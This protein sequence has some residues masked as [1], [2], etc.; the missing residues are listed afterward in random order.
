MKHIKLFEDFDLDKFLENPDKE[1]ADDNSPEINIG[2][3]V[4]S[5]RGKGRVVDMDDSF[6]TVE[7]H[8]SKENRV[9][10]PLFAL[11]KI[12]SDTIET[13]KV[14][15]SKAELADLVSQARQYNDYLNSMEDYDNEED[16]T[17][18]SAS[19]VNFDTLLSF[20][21]DTVVEV[22]TIKNKDTAYDTY[23]EYHELINLVGSIA[24]EIQ[25]ARPDLIDE[26]DAALENFPS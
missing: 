21:Q 7:L 5:Y 17:V 15:D 13:T 9:K 20:I 19:Q 12:S 2:S 6:A 3:Y 8:N 4:D 14:G 24:G 23:S 22:I 25:K 16:D 11:T 26:V 18:Y 1:L 10:V